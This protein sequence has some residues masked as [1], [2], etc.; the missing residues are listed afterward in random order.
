MK[1]KKLLNTHRSAN[2]MVEKLFTAT[3]LTTVTNCHLCEMKLQWVV[4]GKRDDQSSGKVV[5][6]GVAVIGEK[7][8]IVAQGRHRKANLMKVVEILQNWNLRKRTK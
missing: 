7:E 2:H 4:G 5:R 8:A 1:I 6:K 3:Q